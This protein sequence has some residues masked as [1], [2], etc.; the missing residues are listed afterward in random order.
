[1]SDLSIIKRD[2][3]AETEGVDVPFTPVPGIT[4]RIARWQN[5]RYQK[6]IDEIAAPFRA[7]WK[8]G[9]VPEGQVAEIMDRAASEC[10]LVGWT[11]I[12]EPGE[13]GL[14]AV[15]YSTQKSYEYMHD[16]LY[17]EVRMFVLE[18]SQEAERYRLSARKK[19]L[20]N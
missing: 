18:R 13:N 2:I 19:A 7:A 6:R 10:L 20:G 11:G 15:P 1:M 4:L 12:E 16:P 5:P 14:V 17:A 9:D 8:A 3:A